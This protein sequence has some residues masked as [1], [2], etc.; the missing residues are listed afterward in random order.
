M[1]MLNQKTK[2]FIKQSSLDFS[3]FISIGKYDSI[4]R[5]DNLMKILSQLEDTNPFLKKKSWK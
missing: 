4:T 1:L 2:D 3:E 5:A